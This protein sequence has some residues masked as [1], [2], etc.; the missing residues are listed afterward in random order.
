MYKYVLVML[1]SIACLLSPPM[2]TEA[3]TAYCDAII[4]K[5]VSIT[6]FSADD[7]SLQ[8]TVHLKEGYQV[9]IVSV[10][11]DKVAIEYGR[12]YGYVPTDSVQIN[13]DFTKI[14]GN[15]TAVSHNFKFL[16]TEGNLYENSVD[17]LMDYYGSIPQTIRRA[18]ETSGFK[19]KMTDWDVV[20]EAYLGYEQYKP[21]GK[22]QAAFDYEKKILY[23]NDEYPAAVTHEIGHYVNDALGT[24][25]GLE[26]NLKIFRTESVKLGLSASGTHTEFFAEAFRLYVTE[27][28]FLRMVS[29][30][31]Y[32]MVDN[33]VHAFDAK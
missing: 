26:P 3:V 1:F 16:V 19:V 18:Y 28:E 11:L 12:Y 7:V 15:K 8:K 13:S 17:V 2:Y 33:A 24:Y 23:I 22:L 29:P 6:M 32:I 5:D 9:D 31:S 20:D 25:S 10:Y 4:T 21:A 27:P 30:T 14:L